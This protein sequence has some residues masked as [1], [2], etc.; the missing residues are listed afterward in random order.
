MCAGKECVVGGAGDHMARGGLR[1]VAYT[2]SGCVPK[3][4][5]WAFFGFFY[6]ESIQ[7]TYTH[8]VQ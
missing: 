3:A 6:G 7:C 4:R 5:V 2:F 1:L 8:S